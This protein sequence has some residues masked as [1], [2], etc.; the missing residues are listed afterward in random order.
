MPP[1]VTVG[2]ERVRV[3]GANAMDF[4]PVQIGS[5]R[6]VRPGATKQIDAVTE[7]DYATE[8]LMQMKL[9]PAGLRILD[10]LPIENQYPH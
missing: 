3:S 2:N 5:P 7:S 4:D 10:I 9:G 6:S 8:Y 1:I